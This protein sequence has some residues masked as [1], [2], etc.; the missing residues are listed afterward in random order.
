MYKRE[1][2]NKNYVAWR[3]QKNEVARIKN[4]I[5]MSL[6]SDYYGYEGWLQMWY[7][8]QEGE[9]VAPTDLQKKLINFSAAMELAGK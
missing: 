3:T 5:I 7:A 9:F 1:Y 8:W 4:D 2:I 6:P